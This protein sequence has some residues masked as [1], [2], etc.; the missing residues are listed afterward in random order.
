V[1]G[2]NRDFLPRE[3][4]ET[5][6]FAKLGENVLI[7]STA[8]IVDCSGISI[9][10][11]VR[12][13]PFC[14]LS[15]KRIDIGSYVNIS[16]HSALLG[17][18]QIIFEDFSSTAPGATILSSND[19]FLGRSLVGAVVPE[20]LRGA[21]H[22]DVT[23]RRHGIVGTGSVVLPG[24]TIG[25]GSTV[26]A[27]SFVNRSLESWGVYGGVPARRIRDRA[28]NLIALEDQLIRQARKPG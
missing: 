14:V 8:V 1:T 12:I 20:E 16:I 5:L 9:G 7:H 4:L 22:G 11:H 6:G 17:R 24:V 15:A 21:R 18:A 13:D 3:V 26:G 25:E 10:D 2:L 27:L 19:D 23:I 28:K